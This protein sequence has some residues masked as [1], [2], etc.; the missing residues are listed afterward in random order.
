[1]WSQLLLNEDLPF[2]DGFLQSLKWLVDEGGKSNKMTFLWRVGV[3]WRTFTGDAKRFHSNDVS[4]LFASSNP[5]YSVNKNPTA[6]LS[7][8]SDA[9]WVYGLRSPRGSAGE[10]CVPPRFPNHQRGPGAPPMNRRKR[11]SL[12]D[13]DAT[14]LDATPA[15]I[16]VHVAF[17]AQFLLGSGFVVCSSF[18]QFT[19]CFWVKISC[20][21][22]RSWDYR[23]VLTASAKHLQTAV[24]F[25]LLCFKHFFS[26]SVKHIFHIIAMTTKVHEPSFWPNPQCFP[27][28][29]IKSS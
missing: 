14:P 2:P 13:N 29:I 17:Y 3:R 26:C 9:I 10:L 18:F 15:L 25:L 16:T 22:L 4:R 7:G 6:S 1:M 19:N 23:N 12:N 28:R 20:N 27:Q 11:K 5:I 21:S 8:E 24:R